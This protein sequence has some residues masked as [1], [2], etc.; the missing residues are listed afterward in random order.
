MNI[1]LLTKFCNRKACIEIGLPRIFVGAITLLVL[2]LSGILWGGYKLGQHYG[3]QDYVAA[4]DTQ[5]RQ[6][7]LQDRESLEE[8]KAELRTHLDALALR[9]GS[10]RAHTMRLNA[11]GERLVDIG[12]LDQE[13]FN[14][15]MLP[16]VGGL[17]SGAGE[18]VSAADLSGDIERLSSQLQDR[19]NKLIDIEGLLL[20]R[21]LLKEVTPSGRP[22]KKGWVSSSYGRRTDP[23]N[24]KK[25]FHRGIDFAGKTGADVVA[26]ASGVVTRAEKVAGYGNLIEIRHQDGYS[27]RYAHNKENHVTVGDMVEKGQVIALLGS[28]G[29]SNGPHVHFE[30]HKNG[31]IVNP[32]KFVY[33]RK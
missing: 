1:I 21:E 7:L 33:A 3:V 11:L 18:S 10:L 32:R 17:D 5:L 20:D 30:V 16:A 29:R 19:E 4:E 23:F 28:T 26:V 15:D 9:L 25:R 22:V 13:E 31:R 24:G 6:Q 8:T 12:K 14:F 2:V 27:T